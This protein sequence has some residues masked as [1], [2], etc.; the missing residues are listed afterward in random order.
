MNFF[1]KIPVRGK[2]SRSGGGGGDPRMEVVVGILGWGLGSH[3]EELAG[4]Y[5]KELIQRLIFTPSWVLIFQL[6]TFLLKI[7]QNQLSGL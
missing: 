1:I 6:Q 4:A 3:E 5:K 2:P 7:Y